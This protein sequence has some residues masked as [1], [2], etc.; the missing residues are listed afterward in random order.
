MYSN[1]K[2]MNDAR[3]SE[4]TRTKTNGTLKHNSAKF[5]LQNPSKK[6]NKS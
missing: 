4:I 2:G 6:L 1:E 5:C 3:N